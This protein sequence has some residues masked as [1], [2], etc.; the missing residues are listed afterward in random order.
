MA[1]AGAS[2]SETHTTSRK[3]ISQ[4]FAVFERDIA[5]AR[6][7]A[8]SS[9]RRFTTAYNAALMAARATLAAGTPR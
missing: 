4:L 7:E 5:D 2:G 3:E 6:T 8:L 1:G 9:D